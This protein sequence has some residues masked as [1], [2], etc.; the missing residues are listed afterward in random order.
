MYVYNIRFELQMEIEQRHMVS[1]L[2]HKGMKL[3]ATVAELS[4]VDHEDAFDENRVK[5]W[6]HQ[7][8][9]HRS[10]LSDRP[11]FGRPPLKD[12]DARILQ[13]LE[14][15]SW[16]SIRM[17]AE[18]LGIPAST[19]H[20]HLTISLNIKSRHFKWVP[21]FLDD[22]FRIKQLEGAQQFL[23]ALQA[24]K[25]CHFRDLITRVRHR[26]TLA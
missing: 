6:V 17:I 25:R 18:F 19:A 21:H 13:V 7:I 10:D 16:Y 15:E 26:S 22:D 11:S 3:L 2:H 24:Q 12:I 23:D 5:Y 4:A 9:L 20:L 1:C 14:A 8:K